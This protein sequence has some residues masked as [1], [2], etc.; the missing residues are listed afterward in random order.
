M[1]SGLCEECP[2]SE[3]ITYLQVAAIILAMLFLLALCLRFFI[4][5]TRC[6]SS[7]FDTLHLRLGQ[8]VGT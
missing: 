5:Q 6:V 1:R 7:P 3:F 8:S 4:G 2:D